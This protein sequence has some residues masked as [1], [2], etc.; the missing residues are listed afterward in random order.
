MAG[1]IV[2]ILSLQGAFIEHEECLKKCGAVP[3]QIRKPEQMDEVEGLII[4]G[5]ESTAIGKLMRDFGLDQKIIARST[6]GMPIWGTCAGMILLAKDIIA[7]NQ[8]H[9]K[10]M[11]ISVRRNAYGRQV[12]SFETELQVDEIGFCRGVF[13]RAP[14]IEK[15]WGETR[16]MASF[17]ERVVMAKEGNL[18]VTSFH[19]ELT[20]DL[21]IHKYFLEMI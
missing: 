20:E 2:G 21:S 15:V 4:P 14:H 9:L 1:R 3:V 12:D 13:I 17:E 16:I 19:P 18:I 7:M 10:L 8:V 11:D 5:G 6:E